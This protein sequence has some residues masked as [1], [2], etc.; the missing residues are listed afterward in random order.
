MRFIFTNYRGRAGDLIAG[1]SQKLDQRAQARHLRRSHQLSKMAFI[2]SCSSAANSSDPDHGQ[3]R[4]SLQPAPTRL[5][6]VSVYIGACV[7]IKSSLPRERLPVAAEQPRAITSRVPFRRTVLTD[8][9]LACATIGTIRLHLLRVA[10][11][12]VRRVRRLSF[13]LASHWPGQPSSPTVTARSPAHPH[14][15]ATRHIGVESTAATGGGVLA[16]TSGRPFRDSTGPAS[17]TTNIALSVI[18]LKRSVTTGY[19]PWTDSV[20]N[21]AARS[22]PSPNDLVLR[23][24][25]S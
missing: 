15:A 4:Y 7:F 21:N 2:R 17:R 12:V 8:T 14:S 6:Y 25:D 13:H 9:R 22:R 19:D 16:W 20:V 3:W 23:S 24:V 11:R 5:S 1:T 18:D 10:G